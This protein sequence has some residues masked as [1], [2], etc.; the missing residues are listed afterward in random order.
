MATQKQTYDEALK[1][2][3][4]IVSAI[5]GGNLDVDSL[6][7]NLKEA[8]ALLAFCREKLYKVDNEVKKL[9]EADSASDEK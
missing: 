8:Q 2:L 1:R 7:S 3:E 4:A 9:L 6:S 5:E